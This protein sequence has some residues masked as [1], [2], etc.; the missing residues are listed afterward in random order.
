MDDEV[1]FASLRHGYMLVTPH[2]VHAA[3]GNLRELSESVSR[4]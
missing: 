2:E 4:L 1:D 3:R